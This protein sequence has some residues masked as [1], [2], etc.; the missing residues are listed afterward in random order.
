[1]F[2]RYNKLPHNPTVWRNSFFASTSELDFF[3]ISGT[4]LSIV[5]TLTHCVIPQQQQQRISVLSVLV[6]SLLWPPHNLSFFTST[7]PTKHLDVGVREFRFFFSSLDVGI[8]Q[9]NPLVS[10]LFNIH[11]SALHWPFMVECTRVDGALWGQIHVSM[12]Q[13]GM[14][15]IKG[16]VENGVRKKPF[17]I[18]KPCAEHHL[19]AMFQTNRKPCLRGSASKSAPYTPHIQP[20]VVN[21]KHLMNIK[22]T[23]WPIG[24]YGESQHQAMRR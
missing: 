22:W 10:R 24:L 5:L 6:T 1:M 15:Y 8:H 2:R 9:R 19:K 23:C 7:S 12:F 20:Q 16:S 3:F 13:C 14:W 4:V 11:S 21:T 17:S 18:I